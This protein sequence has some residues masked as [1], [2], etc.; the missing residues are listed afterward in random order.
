MT[1]PQNHRMKQDGTEVYKLYVHP[2]HGQA[3]LQYALGLIQLNSQY[4]QVYVYTG[5]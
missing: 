1:K 2:S 4:F 5:R 3:R